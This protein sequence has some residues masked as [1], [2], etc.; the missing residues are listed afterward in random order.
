MFASRTLDDCKR[1]HLWL[2]EPTDRTLEVFELRDG[3]WALI[4]SAEGMTI[5]SASAPSRRSRSTWPISSREHT[6]VRGGAVRQN[7]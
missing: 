4:G 3:E 1:L 5:R 6:P 2:I 7:E